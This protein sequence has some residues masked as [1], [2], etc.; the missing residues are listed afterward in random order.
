MVTNPVRLKLSQKI[1]LMRI[2]TGLITAFLIGVGCRAYGQLNFHAGLTTSY[3][4]TFV[5]DEGLSKDPRYNSTYTYQLS[6]IGV[7]VGL[8]LVK[9]FGVQLE[10]ILSNQG[11]IYQLINTAKEISGERKIDL[12]YLHLPLMMKLMSG[13][14]KR[15]R[16]NF[17]LGP[18]L[19][20]L[21]KAV[22]SVQ[23]KAGTFT[24][25]EGLDFQTVRNDFPNAVNNNDGT[26]TIPEDQPSTSLFS[27]QAGDFKKAEF[28]LALA[29]GADVDL[30][31]HL[32]LS[33]QV[34]ANYSLM[35]MRNEE[36]IYAIKAKGIGD[37]FGGR[38]NFLVGVQVG[39]HYMLGSTRSFK[40]K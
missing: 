11:Q 37:V 27:K 28:Q 6:P 13:G 12:Q 3:N 20:L 40:K 8:D 24:I 18:Q 33:T 26:Y 39:L 7:H 10:S 16:G 36:I 22:E 15:V 14:K 9:S 1:L 4:A 30:T 25:P 23:A 32:F 29:F 31:E 34:R 21:T 35:D 17:N 2:I 5:L 38:A 19:S